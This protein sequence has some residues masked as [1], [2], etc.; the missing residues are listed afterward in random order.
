MRRRLT[1]WRPRK[2]WPRSKLRR[3][4]AMSINSY[5]LRHVVP[6]MLLVLASSTW[7]HGFRLCP[8]LPMRL[9]DRETGILSRWL[10]WHLSRHLILGYCSG[11]DPRSLA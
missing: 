3:E 2:R 4:G 8:N 1:W 5:L 11:V 6:R 10:I 9:C 7:V